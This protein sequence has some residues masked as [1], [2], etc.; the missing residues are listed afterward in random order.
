MV[1]EQN[2][3]V[4]EIKDHEPSYLPDGKW[5]LVWSDEFDGAEL[6]RTKWDFRLNFWGKESPTFSEDAVLDGKGYLHLPLVLDNGVY[7]SAHLQTG[8]LT[9]DIPNK[10]GGIWPFGK[11]R[12]PKFMHKFGYY[13][14]RCNLPKNEGWHAGFWLQAPG[15]GVHP[16]P[17]CCGVE[18]DIMES[19][20][21]PSEGNIIC[22][23]GYGGYGEDS[24]WPGHFSFPVENTD[25]FHTYAV[26]W[27]EDG[28]IFYFDSKE[29]GRRMAP[30]YPVSH[31]DQFILVSTECHG[32][33]RAF[34]NEVAESDPSGN[35]NVWCGEPVSTLKKAV[36]PDEWIVDYV[37]VYDRIK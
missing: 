2:M 5:N 36:L 10:Q 13:E 12:E 3:N 37:R 33:H 15:I 23:I 32:Y 22:G 24:R 34:C 21:Q 27:S 19:Y 14:I 7:K 31:V 25:E 16:D 20:R 4:Y 11:F 1:K 29:V 9:Y 28:Y 30:D 35:A 26:D 6:D 17:K 18:V 8:S